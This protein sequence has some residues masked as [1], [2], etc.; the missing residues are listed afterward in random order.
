[1]SDFERN[2]E[3]LISSDVSRVPGLE[4]PFGVEF[5]LLVGHLSWLGTRDFK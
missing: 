2:R 1:M 4:F 5:K 3:L